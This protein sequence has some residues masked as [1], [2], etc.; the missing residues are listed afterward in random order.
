MRLQGI[1][2]SLPRPAWLGIWTL[3]M[4]LALFTMAFCDGNRGVLYVSTAI[5]GMSSG[6]LSSVAVVTSSELF[7]ILHC[8]VNHNILLSTVAIGSIVFDEM[9]EMLY[10]RYATVETSNM[11]SHGLLCVGRDC[12][13]TTFVVWGCV[14]LLGILVNVILVLRT[15]NLYKFLYCMQNNNT[16][17]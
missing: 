5:I 6:A 13:A 7:G 11:N 9:A 17:L 8:T 14:C 3:P 1:K 15:R 12:F 10:D 16:S 4:L 2:E